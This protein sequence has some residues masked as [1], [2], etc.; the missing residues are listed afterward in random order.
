VAEEMSQWLKALVALKK[1][2]VSV[3]SSHRLAH[4]HPELQFQGF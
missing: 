3:L 1:D 4:N 2:P